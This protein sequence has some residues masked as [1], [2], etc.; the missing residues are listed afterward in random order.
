MPN[1][2]TF[3]IKPIR[4]FVDKYLS[5]SSISVDPY[6]RDSRLAT[7]R[8]DL[9]P[10]TLAEYHMDATEFLVKLNSDGVRADLVIIDPPYSPRQVKECYD[11]FGHKMKQGDAMLGAVRKKLKVAIDAILVKGGKVLT[12]GWNTVGMG[13]TFGYEQLE[14]LLVCH[15][16]D[17]NDTICLAEGKHT[18]R[19][20]EITNEPD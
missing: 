8:N 16:S 17:H 10:N 18:S 7:Y 2:E 20:A 3:S 19:N 11:S 15:G 13:K 6:A 1:N 5:D 9:N 4:L 12:F 14:I